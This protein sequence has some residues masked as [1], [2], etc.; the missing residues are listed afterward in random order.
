M[1]LF[2]FHFTN[3]VV[4]LLLAGLLV[5]IWRTHTNW[6]TT[7]WR[8]F[9]L[10]ALYGVLHGFRELDETEYGWQAH[11]QN[12]SSHGAAAFGISLLIWVLSPH[13]LILLAGVNVA[14]WLLMIY[15]GYHTLDHILTTLA[16]YGVVAGVVV[17][18]LIKLV[19]DFS[20][21]KPVLT[22]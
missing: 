9:G 1:S 12:F 18:L 22:P 4:Y 2:L 19:P 11:G 7:V 14:Y 17:Y 3:S 15:H 5:V 10:V 21:K 8:F 13:F 20:P 16:V 6:R